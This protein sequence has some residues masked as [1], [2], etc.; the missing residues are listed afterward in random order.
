MTKRKLLLAAL[1]LAL[2]IEGFTVYAQIARSYQ[3]GSVWNIV[4]IHVK[5]GM[6]SA[7]M[8][9]LVTDWKNEQDAL[10]GAGLILSYKVIGVEWH[11]PGEFNLMLMT[12]YKSLAA[13]EADK[14]KAEA[15]L[16]KRVTGN[17]Q[18]Q[19]DQAQVEGFNNRTELRDI[20]G[21][22]VG[23]EVILEPKK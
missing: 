16:A 15:L 9:Y 11:T 4:F 8:K 12:E 21:Y 3:G 14:D 7:Y 10:K 20:L 22:R 18:A 19:K 5:P 2:A 17:D 1:V 13:M 23:R 6:E